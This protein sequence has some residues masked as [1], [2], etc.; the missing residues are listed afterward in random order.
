M[1]PGPAPAAGRPNAAL[2][3]GP[4]GTRR[5]VV[6]SGAGRTPTV[7]EMTA[8]LVVTGGSRRRAATIGALSPTI[9]DGTIPM[10]PGSDRLADSSKVIVRHGQRF[11]LIVST[12]SEPVP[13]EARPPVGVEGRAGVAMGPAGT[14]RDLMATLGVA[15]IHGAMLVAAEAVPRSVATEAVPRSAATEAVPR[16]AETVAEDGTPIE[17]PEPVRAERPSARRHSGAAIQTV[18]THG[19][20]TNGPTAASDPGAVARQGRTARGGAATARVRSSRAGARTRATTGSGMRIGPVA[21]LSFRSR[22]MPTRGCWTHPSGRS[23][24]RSASWL[25][26]TSGGTSSQLAA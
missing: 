10:V 17:R 18:P 9:A 16:S 4:D 14:V 7:V 3:T 22:R 5:V 11:V 25:P 21:S 6:P 8:P 1:D 19:V 24:V 15:V 26:N 20:A 23:F 13:E 2:P 12:D